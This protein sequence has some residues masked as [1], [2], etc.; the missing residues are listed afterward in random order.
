MGQSDRVGQLRSL[1]DAPADRRDDPAVG[2]VL[3]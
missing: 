2:W 1:I 3:A